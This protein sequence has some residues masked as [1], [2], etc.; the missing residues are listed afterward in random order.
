MLY[1]YVSAGLNL[2]CVALVVLLF[3]WT[4]HNYSN[5]ISQ[6]C[7]NIGSDNCIGYTMRLEIIF[8][9]VSM[10]CGAVSLILW[11]C[12]PAYDIKRKRQQVE[13]NPERSEA[14]KIARD[15]SSAKR[16]TQTVNR[17]SIASEGIYEADYNGDWIVDD[18]SKLKQT[19]DDES[20]HTATTDEPLFK[21]FKRA[22]RNN[23]NASNSQRK[24][25]QTPVISTAILARPQTPQEDSYKKHSP[26]Y[27]LEQLRQN[28]RRY[29]ELRSSFQPIINRTGL[30]P[31]P[32]VAQ[33][34]QKG[35][36]MM[37]MDNDDDLAPPELP[38]AREKRRLSHGS[39][40]TFGQILDSGGETSPGY[41]RRDSRISYDY[42]SSA[43]SSP[44][45]PPSGNR[46][47]SSGS[48][49]LGRSQY[50]ATMED[51]GFSMTPQAH[52][53]VPGYHPLNNKAIT[54]DRIKSYLGGQ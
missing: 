39:G 41:D 45:Y 51:R 33:Q 5:Q 53:P 2:I 25:P 42:D 11:T 13:L 31:P 19:P 1:I 16:K 3:G 44:G 28:H 23:V 43:Q 12:V 14:L 17:T 47:D 50:T 26:V 10:A 40:N 49:G 38:F 52:T 27:E 29:S 48:Y 20:T 32:A 36:T 21:P 30:H 9:I 18:K 54:D 37:L 6:A 35:P 4:F 24:K 34:K 15:P 46:R 22:A 8:M 7:Y